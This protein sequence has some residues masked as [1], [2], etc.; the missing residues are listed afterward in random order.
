MTNVARFED[1]FM[2]VRNIAEYTGLSDRTVR[3]LV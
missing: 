2:S 3:K 1:Q